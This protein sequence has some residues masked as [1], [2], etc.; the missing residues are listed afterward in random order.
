MFPP[1]SLGIGT[2]GGNPPHPLFMF[3]GIFHLDTFKGLLFFFQSIRHSR[4][5]S[6]GDVYFLIHILF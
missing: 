4:V 3:G 6:L 5:L 1:E 2:I